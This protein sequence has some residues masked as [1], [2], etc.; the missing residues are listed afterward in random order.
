MNIRKLIQKRLQTLGW[1]NYRLWQECKG[2][3]SQAHINR[4]LNGERDI[5]SAYL[6]EIIHA[7]G[8]EITE[9]KEK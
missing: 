8:F 3:V 1:S 4:F 6:S 5:T 2:K 9:R 7:I